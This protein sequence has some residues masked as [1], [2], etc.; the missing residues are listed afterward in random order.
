[1]FCNILFN[2]L[3]ANLVNSLTHFVQKFL[4]W[5]CGCMWLYDAKEDCLYR[6]ALVSNEMSRIA[7]IDLMG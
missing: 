7:L 1:M 3:N 2:P 6:R 4:T 5:S